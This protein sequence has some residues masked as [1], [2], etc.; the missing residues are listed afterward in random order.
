MYGSKALDKQFTNDSFLCNFA[1]WFSYS[2]DRSNILTNSSTF[3]L[4]LIFLRISP[5]AYLV[6]VQ[7]SV[8]KD[9]DI[10]QDAGKISKI[11]STCLSN[12]LYQANLLG[13]FSRVKSCENIPSYSFR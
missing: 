11:G 7:N 4:A 2:I 12:F 13:I 6:T 3:K 10:A 8:A 1:I 9:V 5:I